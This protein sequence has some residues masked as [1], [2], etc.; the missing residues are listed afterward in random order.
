MRSAG[1]LTTTL[2]L[3]AQA[4]APKQPITLAE[5]ERL[6]SA[7]LARRLVGSPG[8]F[9]HKRLCGTIPGTGCETGGHVRAV[10][11]STDFTPTRFP[12]LCAADRTIV[13]FAA[14]ARTPEDAIAVRASRPSPAFRLGRP[15]AGEPRKDETRGDFTVSATGRIVG[16]ADAW[17]VL[18]VAREARAALKR[19][20]VPVNCENRLFLKTTL[21]DDPASALDEKRFAEMHRATISTG[22]GPAVRLELWGGSAAL[23]THVQA[24]IALAALPGD[25][26]QPFAVRSVTLREHQFVD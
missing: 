2:L 9:T 7:A 1:L 23:P 10:V 5:V 11:L 25:S 15:C 17:L 12:D 20:S 3:T 13:D 16:A 22:R 4:P 6:Q 19:A 18:Q 26:A 14:D 21:C 8:R 24:D